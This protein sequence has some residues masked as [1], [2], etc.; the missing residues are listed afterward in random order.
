M[1]S[2]PAADVVHQGPSAPRPYGPARAP[3]CSMSTSTRCP[4]LSGVVSFMATFTN[5]ARVSIGFDGSCG[6]TRRLPTLSSPSS[7]LAPPCRPPD[8]PAPHGPP[9]PTPPPPAPHSPPP[10]PLAPRAQP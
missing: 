10:P 8:P 2:W 7:V 5:N 6:L 3:H 4:S 1:P 9:P